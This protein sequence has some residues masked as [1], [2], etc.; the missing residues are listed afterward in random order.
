MSKSG[1]FSTHIR[2][3][4]YVIKRLTSRHPAGDRFAV[5][6]ARGGSRRMRQYLDTLRDAGVRLADDLTINADEP[7]TVR[8]RWMKGP[9]LLEVAPVDPE[10]FVD[11]VAV[12]GQWVGAL[13]DTDARVDTNLTNFCLSPRGPVLVD[14]LPAL[15]PSLRPDPV[16]LFDEL[17]QALC[18]DTAVTLDALA[19]YAL[20]AL[21][22]ASVTAGLRLPPLRKLPIGLDH[23]G[24][25]GSWFH[26]RA[27]LAT[28]AASGEV[29]PSVV[30]EFFALTSVLGFRQ[31][32]EPARLLRIDHV[33]RRIEELFLS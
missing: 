24:F 20:R 22:N 6:M 30:G 31:L 17:F 23:E 7:L 15:I 33:D 18:F 2:R 29:S 13:D 4:G 14:V 10:Q 11:A 9:T 28:S 21:I 26:A 8:H 32:D 1:D 27:M 16:D 12:I 5:A 3:D 19:G 25:P